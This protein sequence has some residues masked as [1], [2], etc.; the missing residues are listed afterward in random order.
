MSEINVSLSNRFFFRRIAYM[1]ST[2]EKSSGSHE[3]VY[4]EC[5][6][7]LDCTN[8]QLTSQSVIDNNNIIIILLL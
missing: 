2:L 8:E 5:V 6:I 7:F 1:Q 4:C 3:A